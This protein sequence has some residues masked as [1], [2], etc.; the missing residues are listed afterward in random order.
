MP[1]N[2]PTLSALVERIA[3]DIEARLPGADAR[4]RRSN[5][6]V[7]ARIQA[8][9]AHG[10]YGYVDFVARQV[11]PDTAD[12]DY[13]E[14]WASVWGIARKSAVAATGNVVFSGS[15][16][17]QIPAGVV[18]QRSDGAEFVT[19][20]T[21]VI[22]GGS[23]SIAVVAR[24]PGEGGNTPGATQL[25]LAAQILGVSSTAVTA[26]AGL[27]SGAEVEA[28]DDLRQR[29]LSRIQQ[30][31]QGGASNDYVTWALE[32]PGVTRAWVF[33]QW[34]GAGTVGV[35]FVRDGDEDIFPDTDA[36]QVVADY[37]E[38][39]RPVTAELYVMAPTPQPVNFTLSI[40]PE[41]EAVR[42]AVQAELAD[43]FSREAEP[44]GTILLSHLNE[45]VSLAT[46]E[47][48]HVITV[49]ATD[50]EADPGAM[51]TLGV[52]TWA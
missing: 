41:S 24:V 4:L 6:S 18:L 17:T 27:V 31:P 15:N 5:L 35:F 12:Q 52:I 30:P 22:A 2:R 28:D 37:I 20:A 16:T 44:G 38:A 23:A 11:I 29:L 10:L 1:F 14:R 45:A 49:P 50:V 33:P 34:L 47:N 42:Q 19:T 51:P 3:A 32:V 9:V 26:A 7:L 13:L 43:L 21:G 25:A 39:R 46:G 40:S 48:D 8:G 36:V